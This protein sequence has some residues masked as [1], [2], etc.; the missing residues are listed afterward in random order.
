MKRFEFRLESVLS[1]CRYELDRAEA[2]LVEQEDLLRREQLV[3]RDIQA[4]KRRLRTQRRDFQKILDFTMMEIVS[5]CE[6]GVDFR[7]TTQELKLVDIHK[8]LTRRRRELKDARKKHRMYEKLKEKAL[9]EYKRERQHHEQAFL[10]EI[11][12][13]ATSR[14]AMEV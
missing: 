9:E 6:E 14:K 12:V 4:E 7:M 2:R 1:L 3:L 8:E 10:D 13:M 5:R 11:S